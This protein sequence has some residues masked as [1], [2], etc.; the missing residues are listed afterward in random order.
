MSVL[1]LRDYQIEISEKGFKQC[2]DRRW[3]Y[4]AMQVRTGK[5]LTA[6]SIA[7]KLGGQKKR[8]VFVTKKKAIPSIENDVK[9]FNSK[10]IKVEV[11]NYESLH[12]LEINHH[13]D[14]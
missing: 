6:L 1:K 12:K 3:C 11:I 9:L 13:V 14:V 5:S 10:S 2:L 7:D 4:L 8:V